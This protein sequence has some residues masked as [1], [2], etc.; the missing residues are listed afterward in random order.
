MKKT[1]L[2]LPLFAAACSYPSFVASKTLKLEVPVEDA[3]RLECRTHNGDITVTTGEATDKV[4][5]RAEL[6]VRGHTQEEADG[7]LHQMSLRHQNVE[8]TLRLIRDLPSSQL[9]G[10]SPSY[11]FTLMV[12]SDFALDL[13]THNGDVATSGTRGALKAHSHNGDIKSQV[14]SDEVELDTHNGDIQLAIV[15]INRIDSRIVTHNGDVQVFV[16]EDASGWVDAHTHNGRIRLPDG[17]REAS[18]NR[19]SA[20]GRFGPEDAEGQ[21]YVKTHNG[22]VEIR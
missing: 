4:L 14:A 13:Q 8:G 1:F 20:R 17:V 19:R 7:N 18:I 3:A 9:R 5:V 16:P 12:P 21:V 2:L 22:N 10:F 11:T 15:G 6:K